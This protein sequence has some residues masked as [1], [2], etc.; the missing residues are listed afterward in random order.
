MYEK[1][2]KKT[3]NIRIHV[4]DTLQEGGENLQRKQ[5]NFRDV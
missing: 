5:Y 1:Y 3:I 4:G 2:P